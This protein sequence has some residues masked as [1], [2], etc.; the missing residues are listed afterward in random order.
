MIHPYKNVRTRDFLVQDV[1]VH[2]M[3]EGHE[4][5]FFKPGVIPLAKKIFIE[6][7]APEYNF[8]MIDAE[9]LVHMRLL[10]EATTD[11][12]RKFQFLGGRPE[13]QVVHL[14][15]LEG[16]T[17]EYEVKTTY[18]DPSD[19]LEIELNVKSWSGHEYLKDLKIIGVALAGELK[20]QPN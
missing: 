19:I 13:D 5:V 15:L 6:T 18:N 8:V 16:L 3:H 9:K 17:Y 10:M 4:L 11:S 1:K 14:A 7:T 20:S 12:G 2:A